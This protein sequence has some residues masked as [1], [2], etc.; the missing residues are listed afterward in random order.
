V[1]RFDDVPILV[2]DNNAYARRITRS[3]LSQCGIRTIVEAETGADALVRLA[4]FQPAVILME[5]CLPLMAGRSLLA[6]VRDPGRSAVPDVPVL[7]VT[8]QTTRSLVAEAMHVGANGVVLKPFSP[9]QR[10]RTSWGSFRLGRRHDPADCGQD[11][12]H[13]DDWNALDYGDPALSLRV[14]QR[15]SPRQDCPWRSANL[16]S[17]NVLTTFKL[18]IYL[19]RAYAL[20]LPIGRMP[21]GSWR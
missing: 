4:E 6:L 14:Y 9:M 21:V 18:R 19:W 11:A 17:I 1:P 2:V 8:G 20:N 3:I 15:S 10:P 12:D 16:T 13:D 7:V 5:W